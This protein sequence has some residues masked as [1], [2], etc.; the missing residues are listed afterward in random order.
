V[1]RRADGS[2]GRFCAGTVKIMQD[3][4][5][6]NFTAAVIDDYLDGQGR[7]S[8]RR[9]LSFVEPTLLTE[10]V[11]RL[12]GLGFQ[13]HVHAIGERAV[14]EALD[15][16]E[17][18]R[19]SAGDG[20]GRHH[21]AHLQIVHPADIPR[22]AELDVTANMQ[23]F[24]ACLDDQMRDLNLPFLGPERSGWQYPFASL[25][26]AGTRLAAGSDWSVSTPDAWQE[27]Q[28]AVT[29]IPVDRPDQ[30]P[31]I[32]HEAISLEEGLFAFT[33]G[34]AYVNHLDD[35]GTLAPGKSA[36]LVVLDRNPFEL[37]PMEIH[38]TR[39]ILTLVQ[40]EPVFADPTLPIEPLATPR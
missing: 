18:A 40:G 5:C 24:W 10:A 20:S 3:G 15:A 25:L 38:R 22:F 34:S 35:T 27:M 4:I 2:V 30:D 26:A 29:R 6:E 37:P 23:P 21:I 16:F 12:D 17:A 28:V 14:R 7:P 8:G 1:E 39:T 32:P 31:F 11:Q 33:S 9:G 19:R 36:D 13:V